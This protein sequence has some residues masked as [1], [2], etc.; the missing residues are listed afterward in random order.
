MEPT[1]LEVMARERDAYRAQDLFD[2]LVAEKR[3]EEARR[4]AWYLFFNHGIDVGI[5]GG[6]EIIGWGKNY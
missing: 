1:P 4:T 2:R 6:R 5:D 3:Y